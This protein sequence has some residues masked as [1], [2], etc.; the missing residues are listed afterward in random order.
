MTRVMTDTE[1]QRAIQDANETLRSL[2]SP[3]QSREPLPEHEVRRREVILLRQVTVYKILDARER[4]GK[5]LELFNTAI[6]DMMTSFLESCQ[7]H[8]DDA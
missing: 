6:Y 7:Y 3:C 5:D 4:G 1:L 8:S 2:S